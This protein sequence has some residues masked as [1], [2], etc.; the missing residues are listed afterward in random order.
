MIVD[1]QKLKEIAEIEFDDIVEDV[2][3]TDI[4]QLRIILVDGSLVFFKTQ[5]SL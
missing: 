1:I 2:I 3:T 5:G 4:N